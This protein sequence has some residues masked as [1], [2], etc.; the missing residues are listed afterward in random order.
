MNDSAML[1]SSNISLWSRRDRYCRYG[2]AA[3]AG[4]RD[5]ATDG[6]TD[7][8][9]E[10][11]EPLLM[12]LPE[13]Y[14][15]GKRRAPRLNCGRRVATRRRSRETNPQNGH[16]RPKGQCCLF[17]FVPRSPPATTT[18]STGEFYRRTS[19]A[20]GRAVSGIIE[21][22]A[23]W[24]SGRKLHVAPLMRRRFINGDSITAFRSL[25]TPAPD[26]EVRHFGRPSA[27]LDP[28]DDGGEP[29]ARR[30]ITYLPDA[31]LEV[32][33]HGVH[34]PL[35]WALGNHGLR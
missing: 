5:N 17:E 28:L 33:K 30:C 31:F 22:G 27:C 8:G 16:T 32:A 6:V 10:P 26:G 9:V 18:R 4:C 12:N 2:S 25:R 23:R 24:Q 11:V 13:K 3:R 19:R 7:G 14:Q 20:R 34:L 15:V 1:S 21:C 35:R 29:R